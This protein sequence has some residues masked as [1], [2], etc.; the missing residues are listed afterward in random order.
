MSV[1]RRGFLK[2]SAMAALLTA[3][4]LK[5]LSA[6]AAP[7]RATSDGR[8]A[9]ADRNAVEV[10]DGPPPDSLQAAFATNLNSR[11]RIAASFGPVSLVLVA[12]EAFLR[13]PHAQP[14]SESFSLVF[15]GAAT[16]FLAQETY[17]CEHDALGTFQLFLVPWAADDAG[18]QRYVAIVNRLSNSPPLL[19]S[20]VR[21]RKGVPKR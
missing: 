4:E 10:L 11:F 12:V 19:D 21:T 1:S 2:G 13:W 5:N 7:G 20:K 15:Q 18:H 6:A 3:A 8:S 17:T 14:D 16:S 9:Q